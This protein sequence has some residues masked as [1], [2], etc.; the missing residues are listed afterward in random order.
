MAIGIAFAPRLDFDLDE[1]DL[2]LS[3]L[4]VIQ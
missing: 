4:Q 3:P 1:I 2:S